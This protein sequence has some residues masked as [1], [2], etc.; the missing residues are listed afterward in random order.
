MTHTELNGIQ[1][2]FPLP[3]DT[4][5]QNLGVVTLHSAQRVSQKYAIIIA[6]MI[7]NN[8]THFPKGNTLMVQ[9]EMFNLIIM[10]YEKVMERL[11]K[12]TLGTFI[13]LAG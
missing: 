3:R 9:L 5:E 2:L 8:R 7:I 11:Q 12:P 1:P 13:L 6:V 4:L 10:L